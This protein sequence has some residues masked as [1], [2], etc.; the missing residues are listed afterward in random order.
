[1]IPMSHDNRLVRDTVSL[2]GGLYA[3]QNPALLALTVAEKRELI[4]QWLHLR[5]YTSNK[6]QQQ[7]SEAQ[8][9]DALIAS[10]LLLCFVEVGLVVHSI[11]KGIC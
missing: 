5:D 8:H 6:L 4:D 2:L 11:A 1:M 10:S 7:E 9:E 3:Y